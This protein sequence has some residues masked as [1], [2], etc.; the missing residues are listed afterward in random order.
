MARA[1]FNGSSLSRAFAKS[2]TVFFRFPLSASTIPLILIPNPA[3]ILLAV[4]VGLIRDAKPDLSAFAPSEALIPPSFMAVRKNAKS[5]TL[6]PSCLTTGAAFGIAVVKSSIDRTVWFSTALRKL[7]FLARSSAD[8]PNAFVSD[9]VVSKA[10][11]WSTPPRTA[12]FV[13][14]VT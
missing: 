13:A 5:S 11:C 1:R 6:P 8:N 2:T 3:S 4:L 12:S 9:I 10:F 14:L 7:I